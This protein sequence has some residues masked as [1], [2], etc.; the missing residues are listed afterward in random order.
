MHAALGKRLI[1]VS[2]ILLGLLAG[3]CGGGGSGTVAGSSGLGVSSSSSAASSGSSAST[4][5]AGSAKKLSVTNHWGGNTGGKGGQPQQ[6]GDA[7]SNFIVD[8]AVLKAAQLPNAPHLAP[9]VITQS[10]WDET[11]W[12]DGAYLNGKRESKGEFYY[13]AHTD[14]GWPGIT[15]DTTSHNGKTAT[16]AHPSVVSEEQKSYEDQGLPL[17]KFASNLPFVQLSDGRKITSVAY[18]TGLAFDDAGRLWVADN[19]PDQNFKIFNL[20]ASGAPTQVATFGETGGV[21]AGPVKGRTGEKRFWGP[22][23]VGFG[24]SGE[25]IVGTSGIPGQVQGGTDIR[26][27]NSAGSFLWD[28]KGIF[29]HSPDIDP[30]SNGTQI[31]T[32]AQRFEMDYS[33]A[34][35]KSWRQAA[36]TLDPFRFPNDIR[37]L[38]A[39]EIAFVRVING[40]KFLF[41]SDMYGL[42]VA[43]FRFEA[44][45]EIAIPA[46]IFGIG[47]NERG[48]AWTVGKEPAWE[49]NE[50]FNKNRRQAW[51]D[52]NG[53]GQVDA[54]EFFSVQMPFPFARGMD[55]DDNG[56]LWV[57]GKFNAHNAGW[58]EGGNL[59]IPFG[60]IDA[61]GVPFSGSQPAFVDVPAALISPADRDRSSGRLRYLSATDTLLM[62]RGEKEDYYSSHIYVIDGYR[63]SNN[64][65]LRF[66][67]DLGYDDLGSE[68]ADILQTDTTKMVLPNVFASDG[69]YIYVGYIDNGPDAKV[70]GEITVY[71][72]VDGHKV[73]WIVPGAETNYF[74][75]NF[76]MRHGIQVRKQ[77]D[78]TRIIVAEENGAGK[79]MVYRWNPAQP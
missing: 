66:K 78:G 57:A 2:M 72:M 21:F 20:P 25:I 69:D 40:R 12:A 39:N 79:F 70:R 76:D 44:N 7:I 26:A 27:F 50:D 74:A 34:P 65:R 9:L 18:P 15:F 37:V 61:N 32:A 19:G 62:A 52:K 45:S 28:V 29:M 47:S 59:V 68:I 6:G 33:K 51:R 31:Y 63:N 16:I 64:P 77:V 30:T 46:A 23:G 71:S 67:L 17:S 75:G 3:A 13:K 73:G 58:R 4:S 5:S 41:V 43:V 60:S 38:T 14:T 8:I 36:I 35:G 54:D 10:Y 55:I 24:D 1:P 56:N 11:G 48:A 53:D 22:R 42:Y 49:G